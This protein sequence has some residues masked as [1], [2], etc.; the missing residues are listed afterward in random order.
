MLPRLK[1]KG[2]YGPLSCSL[3][4]HRHRYQGLN[5]P[6]FSIKSELRTKFSHPDAAMF[7]NPAPNSASFKMIIVTHRK[8]LKYITDTVY[9]E[10]YFFKKIVYV[11]MG[12]GVILRIRGNKVSN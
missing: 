11:K 3:H 6:Q 9:L 7:S 5:F 4:F 2:S 12:E 8:S 10:K 1:S